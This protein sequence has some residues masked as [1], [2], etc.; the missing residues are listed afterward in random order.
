MSFFSDRIGQMKKEREKMGILSDFIKQIFQVKTPIEQLFELA[1]NN[2]YFDEKKFFK[3][4]NKNDRLEDILAGRFTPYSLVD[5]NMQDKNGDTLLHLLAGNSFLSNYLLKKG[6]NASILNNQKQTPLAKNIARIS[7][8]DIPL[9][10]ETPAEELNKIQENKETILTDLFLKN[11]K[12]TSKL[13]KTIL[14][15]GA[16]VNQVN[17]QGHTPLYYAGL[18][19]HNQFNTFANLPHFLTLVGKNARFNE[20][21]L[22]KI[23]LFDTIQT[24]SFLVLGLPDNFKLIQEDHNK[25]TLLFK[26]LKNPID[27]MFEDYSGVFSTTQENLKEK[28]IRK[29]VSL[30]DLNK[31]DKEGKGVIETAL[32]YHRY[33]FLIPL[34]DQGADISFINEN[35]ETLLH[36]AV[37]RE[38]EKMLKS[39]LK[40]GEIDINSQDKNGNTPL[41]LALIKSKTSLIDLLLEYNSNP[42]L[43]N[44]DNR[45]A[46]DLSLKSNSEV[47]PLKLKIKQ[48]EIENTRLNTRLIQRNGMTKSATFPRQYS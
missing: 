36:L 46:M 40:R 25:D 39:L 41:H 21:D 38:D 10:L 7:E 19:C 4:I 8:T 35:K 31:K 20:T 22:N 24:K 28:I 9:I 42:L 33:P 47:I 17:Q 6:A 37:L 12:I 14:D 48:L 44:N 15:K 34:I 18:F 43:L 30:S 29:V 16:N 32:S 45:S 27:Y 3:I 2:Q 26:M 13:L 1:Q 23:N 5:L 11:G